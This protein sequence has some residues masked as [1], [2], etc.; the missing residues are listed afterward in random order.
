MSLSELKE[1]LSMK[2]KKMQ[3]IKMNKEQMRD[4]QLQKR[5]QAK[6]ERLEREQWLRD[7]AKPREDLLCEDLEPLP[8]TRE[9]ELPHNIPANC[10]GE[11]FCL[12]SC[13]NLFGEM[14]DVKNSL[15]EKV[16][17]ESLCT[18]LACTEVD[19]LYSE[20]LVMFLG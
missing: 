19:G 2:E 16:T 5:L 18:A 3:E 14:M 17:V 6:S 8:A 11:I 12:V 1:H 7:W 20:I 10:I 9:I 15:S 4:M 13:C